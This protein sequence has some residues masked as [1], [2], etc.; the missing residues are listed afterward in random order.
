M[1]LCTSVLTSSSGSSTWQRAAQHLGPQAD[2]AL[3]P[4][5]V[6][7]LRVNADVSSHSRSV[8]QGQDGRLL[9]LCAVEHLQ[10]GNGCLT[11]RGRYEGGWRKRKRCRLTASSVPFMQ[12]FHANESLLNCTLYVCTTSQLGVQDKSRLAW[13]RI[14][15]IL[16]K[17]SFAPN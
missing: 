10:R 6:P 14:A 11:C 4:V 16:Q 2:V 7:R 13:K 12:G 5:L 3:R 8:E 1:S 17:K 15:A 9:V